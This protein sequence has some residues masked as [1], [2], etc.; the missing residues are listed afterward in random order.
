[1]LKTQNIKDPRIGGCRLGGNCTHHGRDPV[2]PCRHTCTC[3]LGNPSP[4]SPFP[5]PCTAGCTVRLSGHHGQCRDRWYHPKVLLPSKREGLMMPVR[6]TKAGQPASNPSEYWIVGPSANQ[7]VG[8]GC[9][10]PH[11][12]TLACQLHNGISEMCLSY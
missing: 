9:L 7:M 12:P 2:L 11:L 8:V 3:S 4:S 6:T 1:M 5:S 10:S